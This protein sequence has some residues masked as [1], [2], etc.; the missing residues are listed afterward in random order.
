MKDKK[1]NP[2]NVGIAFNVILESIDKKTGR[3]IKRIETHNMIVNTGL[4]RIAKLLGG[5]DAVG[6][7]SHIAVGTD[8][9]AV[10]NT[11]TTLGTEVE[12]ESATISY[13]AN[14]KCKFQKVFSVGTGVSHAVKEVGIFDSAT[15]TGSVMWAR[16]NAD[17]TLD[18]DT[19]LSV[20]MTYTMARV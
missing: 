10:Q 16:V 5:V 12:R 14:Y 18:F 19:D 20:T 15:P 11:D 13:E 9:T 2:K 8:D 17:N 3:V 7:F 1:K 6:D 4:E